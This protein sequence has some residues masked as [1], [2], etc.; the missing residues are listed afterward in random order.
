M[1][2]LSCAELSIDKECD[3]KASGETDNEV[4]DEMFEHVEEVHKS[5]MKKMSGE[6][7]EEK[8]F[9]LLDAQK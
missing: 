1:K 2:T 3:F 4:I 9:E 7:V 6:D 8:M 5:K